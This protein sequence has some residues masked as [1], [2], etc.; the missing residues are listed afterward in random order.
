MVLRVT[1]LP[2][3]VTGAVVEQWIATV[4][5]AAAEVEHDSAGPPAAGHPGLPRLVRRR[6]PD[7]CDRARKAVCTNRHAPGARLPGRSVL[8]EVSPAGA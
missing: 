5:R 3:N 1:Q 2:G 8:P 7:G 4:Q 6:L